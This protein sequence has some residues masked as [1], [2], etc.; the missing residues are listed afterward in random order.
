MKWFLILATLNVTSGEYE[1]VSIATKY[2]PYTNVEA[3]ERGRV[4]LTQALIQTQMMFGDPDFAALSPIIYETGCVLEDELH[5][6]LTD[7]EQ[8]EYDFGS[9]Q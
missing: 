6:Y 9:D 5:L 8:S 2:G 3:C 4:H 7:E 1:K